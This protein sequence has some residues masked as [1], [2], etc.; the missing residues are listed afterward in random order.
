VPDFP[1]LSNE[2][3][4]LFRFRPCPMAEAL[5]S[6][7]EA[8][9]DPQESVRLGR[10]HF[11]VHRREFLYGR[12]LTRFVL[13]HYLEV[14]PGEV[15]FSKSEFGKP[16]VDG[17]D[18]IHFNL[19]HS[20]GISVLALSLTG[21]VG[22]DLEKIDTANDGVGIAER[23]F[24]RAE[25]RYLLQLS[26]DRRPDMFFALWALKESF[27]KATGKGLSLP[28]ADFTC[29][30][31]RPDLKLLL[32]EDLCAAGPW[33]GELTRFDD[34]HFCARTVAYQDTPPV[35]RFFDLVPG[36]SL[37]SLA[38]EPL[39]QGRSVANCSPSRRAIEAT[40]DAD[41]ELQ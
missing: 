1:A 19:S 10:F 6:R 8:W 27:I 14:G 20:R 34:N 3:V 2:S 31:R 23:Y 37:A 26:A 13:S 28:L 21:P 25:L 16:R 33:H 35:S 12:A 40:M 24:S 9:L 29:E 17:N 18:F 36:A 4:L 11:E 22:V 38:V 30:I 15:R 5:R 41:G 32:P 7:Y 39:A